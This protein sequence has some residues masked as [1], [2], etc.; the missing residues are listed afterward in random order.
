MPKSRNVCIVIP[1]Y[2]A[3]LPDNE[4]NALR[5]GIELYGNSHD[6][7]LVSPEGLDTSSYSEVSKELKI[8][9]HPEHYFKSVYSYN[10]LMMKSSF[11]KT[12][13]GYKYLFLYQLDAFILS[14]R[15]AE[16]CA[17]GYDYIGAPWS[18]DSWI[19][20]M[21]DRLKTSFFSRFFLKVGNGGFSLRNIEKSYR[22]ARIFAPI[23]RFWKDNW[24]E[25]IFWSTICHR[26]FPGYKVA[27]VQ[28]ALAFSIEAD[29]NISLQ[30]L[31]GQL[32]FG[33][34]AWEKNDPEFWIPHFQDLAYTMRI[35]TS[36]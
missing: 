13:L 23:G 4:L 32:P 1:I 12:F 33:C 14:D 20:I 29:P 9:S 35:E 7:Y 8:V 27:P 30:K 17:L 11:Y 18:D 15:L 26:F 2:R 22:I 36:S 16:M 6:L 5:R 34:H 10:R 3:I 31:D 21:D 19:E 24:N 28:D 25:D